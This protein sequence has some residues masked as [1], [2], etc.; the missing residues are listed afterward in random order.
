MNL[1]IENIDTVVLGDKR[2]NTLSF[3]M[4]YNLLRYGNF[5]VAHH[6]VYNGV[7]PLLVFFDQI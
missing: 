1:F 3:I 4:C 6:L 2:H 7:L 5:H